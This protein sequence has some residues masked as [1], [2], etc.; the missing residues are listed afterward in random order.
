M[1]WCRCGGAYAQAL[2]K[3]TLYYAFFSLFV[4][5]TIEI[6]RKRDNVPWAA[7]ALLAL[8]GLLVSFFRN[9]GIYMVI[10]AGLA[11]LLVVRRLNKLKVLTALLGCLVPFLAFT[12]L[13]LP[14]LDVEEG[15]IR[16]AMSLFF[17]Q[18]ARFVRD[19]PDEVTPDEKEVIGKVLDVDRLGELYN[20]VTADPVKFSSS[21]DDP[22]A[23]NAYLRAWGQMFFRHPG[24]YLQALM[25]NTFGYYYPFYNENQMNA[26]QL[27]IKGPPV[28]TGDLDI[29]YVHG[30][31]IRNAAA[32]YAENWRQFPVVSL[33]SNPGAYTWAILLLLTWLLHKKKRAALTVL[34]MPLFNLVVCIASPV[35]GLLRY[36][37]PL[38]AC[39]PLL[40]AF[41]LHETG[42]FRRGKEEAPAGTPSGDQEPGD[43][44]AA[45]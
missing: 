19:Y 30:D 20:P 13:A 38:M 37:M 41:C 18:T 4:V 35:N 25:N 11:M 40:I 21:N 27:Y 9:N 7:V 29:Y 22:E 2:A 12:N 16:E 33:L 45:L 17:Q 44:A 26:Y 10:P 23:L 3:D 28:S 31:G 5:Y 1:L 36:A 34:L 15:S 32:A 43:A 8:S 14:R 6:Y 39:M 42:V 24:T